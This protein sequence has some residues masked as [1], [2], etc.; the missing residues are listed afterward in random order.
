MFFSK[1]SFM[2]HD[3]HTGSLK[4]TLGIDGAQR[5]FSELGAL[6][7]VESDLGNRGAGQNGAKGSLSS[8]PGNGPRRG[9]EG[10]ERW[11]SPRASREARGHEHHLKRLGLEGNE[12][13]RLIL[14]ERAKGR[15]GGK[16]TDQ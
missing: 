15:R 9:L 5:S 8:A 2:T 13:S 16:F 4:E 11:W 14:Y 6:G 10:H 1:N 12:W 7:L 3:L